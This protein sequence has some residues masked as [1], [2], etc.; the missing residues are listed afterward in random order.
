MRTFRSQVE[1]TVELDY[2]IFVRQECQVEEAIY[3]EIDECLPMA[4][5]LCS[6]RDDIFVRQKY[7]VKEAIYEE[8]DECLPMAPPLCSQRDDIMSPASGVSSTAVSVPS[9]LDRG[10]LVPRHAS[11]NGDCVTSNS[12]EM[13]D[14]ID[15]E[16]FLSDTAP[17][18]CVTSNS[19][20]MS[21]GIDN[22]AFLSD[23][24]T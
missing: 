13:S 23:T 1:S 11:N 6:Q 2:D 10:Y 15:N 14:G 12:N 8:I 24:A 17:L 9:E 18:I 22:E 4:P 3:E 21:G 5:P 7:Q 19:N 16:A 20:E